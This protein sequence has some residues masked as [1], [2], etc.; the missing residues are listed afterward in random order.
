MDEL[1]KDYDR[2]I[3]SNEPQLDFQVKNEISLTLDEK[4]KNVIRKRLILKLNDIVLVLSENR[5]LLNYL[6]NTM[7]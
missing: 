1:L 6:E 5:Y 7:I 3:K 2:E 4:S